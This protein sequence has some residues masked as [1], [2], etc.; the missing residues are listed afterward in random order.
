MTQFGNFGFQFTEVHFRQ[1]SCHSVAESKDA[2][3]FGLVMIHFLL[4]KFLATSVQRKVALPLLSTAN[5]CKLISILVTKTMLELKK[6]QVSLLCIFL[7]VS[8]CL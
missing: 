4:I 2:P 3:P 7:T 6:H 5:L 1:S 8:S